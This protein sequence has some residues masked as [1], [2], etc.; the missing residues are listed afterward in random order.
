MH[1]CCKDLGCSHVNWMK[2]NR[3]MRYR[4]ISRYSLFKAI[5]EALYLV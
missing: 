3:L 5:I 4:K 1:S 2:R